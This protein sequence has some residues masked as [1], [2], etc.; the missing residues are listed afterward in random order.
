MPEFSIV[1][2]A[3]NAAETLHEAL[4]SIH[5]Q[6]YDSWEAII[7][8]DGSTDRTSAIAAEWAARDGRFSVVRQP[9]EGLAAARN[10]GFSHAQSSLFCPLDGDDLYLPDFLESQRMFIDEHPGFDVYS[11][12]VDALL[13]D[14]SRTPFNLGP[15]Y[16]AVVETCLRD[17]IERNRFTVICVVRRALFQQL[18]GF[19][20]MSGREDHDLWLRAAAQG[21]RMLHNPDTLALYRQRSNSMSRDLGAMQLAYRDALEHLVAEFTLDPSDRALAASTIKGIEASR[22]RARLEREAEAGAARG[23]LMRLCWDARGSFANRARM[24]TA[25]GLVV[26][27]PSTFRRVVR[28]RRAAQRTLGEYFAEGSPATAERADMP[29]SP[30][31]QP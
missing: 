9:N 4:E 13:S 14:G 11:C 28:S 15:E 16:S 31:A 10:T 18:R 22:A 29:D 6:T 27:S 26:T 1:V 3:F 7:V 25:L 17:L 2:P 23:D 19:R 5:T 30:E 8:D 12:N 20:A 24:M 21:F